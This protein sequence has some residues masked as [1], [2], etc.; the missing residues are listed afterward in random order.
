M[1]RPQK[2][3]QIYREFRMALSDKFPAHELLRSAAKLIE[4]IE[5]DDPITVARVR[6]P[7]VPFDERPVDEA[8]ADGG[9]KILSHE[10]W[11]FQMIGEDDVMSVQ[12]RLQLKGY[13]LEVA[14]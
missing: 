8:I 12:A 10:D 9:W 1:N 5:D 14:A 7:W 4:I 2:I 11:W 13:G 6:D 3:N